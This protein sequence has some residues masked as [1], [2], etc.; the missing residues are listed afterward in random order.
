MCSIASFALTSLIGTFQMM[1]ADGTHLAAFAVFIRTESDILA[2]FRDRLRWIKR[3]S[4]I[5][6]AV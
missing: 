6:A 4:S 2:A 5:L 3:L 1:E